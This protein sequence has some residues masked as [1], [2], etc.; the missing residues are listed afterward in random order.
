MYAAAA[1]RTLRKVC[2]RVELHHVP[3]GTVASFEHTPES[4]QRQVSR[5]EMAAAEAQAAD[6]AYVEAVASDRV[7]EVFTPRPSQRCGWCDFR[8][9]CPE[10]RAASPERRSWDGLPSEGELA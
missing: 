4:L 3:T 5:V 2:R 10:G 7:D 9:N 1:A 8:R 6:A